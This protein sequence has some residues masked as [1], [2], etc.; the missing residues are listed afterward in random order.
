MSK[1]RSIYTNTGTYWHRLRIKSGLTVKEV[2]EL[3]DISQS[4]LSKYFN[5]KAKIPTETIHN[6]AGFFGVDIQEAIDE[7]TRLQKLYFHGDIRNRKAKK[8]KEEE[9]MNDISSTQ[10]EYIK[11]ANY[12][13]LEKLFIHVFN[14]LNLD[15]KDLIVNGAE[16]QKYLYDKLDEIKEYVNEHD[17]TIT[18]AESNNIAVLARQIN[19]LIRRIDLAFERQQKKEGLISSIETYSPVLTKEEPVTN[20]QPDLYDKIMDILYGKLSREEYE[21]VSKLLKEVM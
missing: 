3:M 6:L 7:T 12:S 17:S 11:I 4:Q 13:D 19:T 1:G 10:M 18:E 9:P 16:E 21:E 14:L 15:D 2:A 5:G 8:I 20:V